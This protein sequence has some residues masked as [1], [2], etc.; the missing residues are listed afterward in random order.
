MC[1]NKI[2]QSTET[3]KGKLFQRNNMII[4]KINK[5]YKKNSYKKQMKIKLLNGQVVYN[6]R[7]IK[8]TNKLNKMILI[9]IF[10][11]KLK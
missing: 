6:N 10:Q 3:K 11:K 8:K 5:K 4:K 1:F 7:L 2:V 9:K